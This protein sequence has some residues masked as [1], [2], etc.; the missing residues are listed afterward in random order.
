MIWLRARSHRRQELDDVFGPVDLG[1]PSVCEQYAAAN[2]G[3]C[4]ISSGL[5]ALGVV[6][7]GVMIGVAAGACAGRMCG[8]GQKDSGGYKPVEMSPISRQSSE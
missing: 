3:S 5:G 2:G 4:T 6:L 7:I 8:G 1:A